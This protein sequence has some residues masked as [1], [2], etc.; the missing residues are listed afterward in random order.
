MLVG[1]QEMALAAVAV[2][3]FG[4]LF[5]EDQ[6]E[7][8]REA[9]ALFEGLEREHCAAVADKFRMTLE[10]MDMLAEL[11]ESMREDVLGVIAQH[12]GNA[13]GSG[14]PVVTKINEAGE[15]ES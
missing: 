10:L 5:N 4:K 2:V 12:V 14:K 3:V 13:S 11:P 1:K 7:P 8:I 9:K 6:L 15:E